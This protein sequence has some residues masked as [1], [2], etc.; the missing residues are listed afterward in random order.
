[1][2]VPDICNRWI[3]N[4]IYVYNIVVVIKKI[5]TK[6]MCSLIKSSLCCC[7]TCAMDVIKSIIIFV[8][9]CTSFVY[10]LY[11]FNVIDFKKSSTNL[12]NNT[13]NSLDRLFM[14]ESQKLLLNLS[15]TA[16]SAVLPSMNL[17]VES[18]DE[19]NDDTM[20]KKI[21]STNYAIDNKVD[22]D[23]GK[24]K[25][26]ESTSSSQLP[27]LTLSSLLSSSVLQNEK[28][29]KGTEDTED[30]ENEEEELSSSDGRKNKNWIQNIWTKLKYI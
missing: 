24:L 4:F 26:S 13:N 5:I 21:P 28:E 23:G 1:M 25:I 17:L 30:D 10:L 11:L 12:N 7:I 8:A 3:Y 16:S 19:N 14:K 27:P 6:N 18:R 20:Y 29:N 2:V 15:E 9:V 22:D